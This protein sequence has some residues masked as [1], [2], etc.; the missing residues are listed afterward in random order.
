M[1]TIEIIKEIPKYKR[2]PRCANIISTIPPEVEASQ[3]KASL[4]IKQYCDP[5]ISKIIQAALEKKIKEGSSWTIKESEFK[6]KDHVLLGRNM[7]KGKEESYRPVLPTL[8]LLPEL[9][10]THYKINHKGFRPCLAELSSK[11][12]YKQGLTTPQDIAGLSRLISK[13]CTLCL[14]RNINHEPKL[15]FDNTSGRTT[16]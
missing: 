16:F 11:F 1:L 12:Y 8:N 15:Y 3:E 13:A 14:H 4:A 5:F 7:T 2:N 10:N 6:I 9:V